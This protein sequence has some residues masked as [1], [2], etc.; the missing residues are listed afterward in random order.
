[1]YVETTD[2]AEAGERVQGRLGSIV[3]QADLSIGAMLDKV[4][5]A[6]TPAVVAPPATTTAPAA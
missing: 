3:E 6:P 2:F 5:G 1:M 4:Y